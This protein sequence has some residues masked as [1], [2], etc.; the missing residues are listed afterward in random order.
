MPHVRLQYN[1][2][3]LLR[4]SHSNA[5]RGRPGGRDRV[6][7]EAERVH[8]ASEPWLKPIVLTA[9]HTGMRNGEL[10]S[11]T[12][13]CIDMTHAFIRLK[14]TKNG[15]ARALPFNTTLWGLFSGLRMARYL[16]QDFQQRVSL[17]KTAGDLI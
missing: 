14:Q 16:R 3:P 2:C 11:L 4:Y 1:H 13:D 17:F 7:A 15:K 6:Q 10:L 9:L 12:W 5:P 8:Q